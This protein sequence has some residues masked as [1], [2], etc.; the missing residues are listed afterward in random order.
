MSKVTDCF[1]DDVGGGMPLYDA[2]PEVRTHFATATGIS[3]QT[4]KRRIMVPLFMLS[5]QEVEDRAV[6][7]LLEAV[8]DHGWMA[9]NPF[10]HADDDFRRRDL[11]LHSILT[12]ADHHLIPKGWRIAT[13]EPEQLGRIIRGASRW[14]DKPDSSRGLTL[15]NVDAV[16]GYKKRD[17]TAWNHVLNGIDI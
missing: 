13:A 9:K 10:Q 2:D 7:L 11:R 4:G 15:F 6:Q 16:I 17:R 14:G 5:D 12:S 3:S 8:R 1:L